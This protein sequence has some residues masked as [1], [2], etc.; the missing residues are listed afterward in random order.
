MRRAL[1]AFQRRDLRLLEADF[2]EEDFEFA[3]FFTAVE[4]GEAVYRGPGAWGDYAAVM[5]EMWEDWRQTT[6]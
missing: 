3:S 5:D 2:C 4:A 6:P 1:E